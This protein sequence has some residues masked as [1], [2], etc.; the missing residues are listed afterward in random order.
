MPGQLVKLGSAPKKSHSW[1]PPKRLLRRSG[2]PIGDRPP[3]GVRGHLLRVVALPTGGVLGKA[4]FPP[5]VRNQVHPRRRTSKA[6]ADNYWLQLRQAEPKQKDAL[7][8]PP[9]RFWGATKAEMPCP[10]HKCG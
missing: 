7:I 4:G 1:R 2:E 10:R 5:I 6:I 8:Y 3:T 9:S